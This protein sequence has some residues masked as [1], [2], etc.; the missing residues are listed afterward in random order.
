MNVIASRYLSVARNALGMDLAWLSEHNGPEQVLQVVDGNAAPFN[1]AAGDALSWEGSFCT[2]VLD[3]RLPPAIPDTRANP[4]TV[5]LAVTEQVGIGSYIGSP[6]RLPDGT[7]YGMLCCISRGP[8]TE[9]RDHHVHLLEALAGSLGAEMADEAHRRGTPESPHFRIPR[10]IGGEGLRVV[11]QPIVELATMCPV[12]VE[13]L[14]RFDVA[15]TR[16]DV[17]FAEAAELGLGLLLEMASI[18][19]ALALLPELP[20]PLYVSVNVSPATLSSPELLQALAEVDASRV[21]VEVTEHSSVADYDTLLAGADVLRRMGARIAVDDAGAGYASFRHILA[22]RPDVIKFDREMVTQLDV[23][24]ARRAL[25]GALVSFAAQMGATLVAEGV[26]T[27]GELD[28]L[29]QL[30]VSC[31]QGYHLARP[32]PLP[33]PEIS[34]RPVSLRRASATETHDDEPPL[35]ESVQAVLRE[36]VTRTGLDVSYLT[37]WDPERETLE[38]RI[39]YDPQELGVRVGVSLP[40]SDTPC[41]RC[42]QAGILW[43][44]DVQNDLAGTLLDGTDLRTFVSVP[45]LGPAG[46]MVGTLCAVGRRRRYLSDPVLRH[47]EQLGG[48]I[49]ELLARA[50]AAR[51]R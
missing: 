50:E 24:P 51:A 37:V 29:A 2:R 1:I 21:L 36:V 32:G 25:V 12:G 33:L 6:V 30:G 28:V 47:V 9:L 17:W 46:T 5:E 35:D 48:R 15:P 14:T 27:A 3:N 34:A 45:V 39:V 44:A 23:D 26:E 22:L 41:Y 8:H 10:A 40:F 4:V 16:P 20:E 43:T 49:A 7:L 19:A 18:R 42:Q 13:A 11:V 38:H 31:G